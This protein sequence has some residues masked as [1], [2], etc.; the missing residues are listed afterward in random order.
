M[1]PFEISSPNVPEPFN[2]PPLRVKA[3]GVVPEKLQVPL[4]TWKISNSWNCRRLVAGVDVVEI[5]RA[6]TLTAEGQGVRAGTG[7]DL[8]R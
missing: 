7:E 2:V 3:Y 1:P 4:S 6:M 8:C 5:E